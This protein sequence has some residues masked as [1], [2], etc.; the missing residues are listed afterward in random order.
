[1]KTKSIL[2]V[3][4]CIIMVVGFSQQDVNPKSKV[5]VN[6]KNDNPQGSGSSSSTGLLTKTNFGE[7]CSMYLNESFQKGVLVLNDNTEIGDRLY[8]FNIYNQQMEFIV[9]E[10]TTAIGNPE[11][12]RLLKF[13][14]KYFIYTQYNYG[15]KVNAGY[16]EVLVDGDYRLLLHRDIKYTFKEDVT[17][18]T[19]KP[20]ERYY[21]GKRYFISYKNEPANHIL[22][23]KKDVVNSVQIP[24]KDLKEYMKERKNH[25]KSESDLVEVFR[26]CNTP[27]D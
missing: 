10:D 15:Q 8:R 11:E 25:M 24:G 22:L 2:T 17:D 5:K 14:G 12:L 18:P 4:M 19:A 1:M 27:V 3:A 23:D 26:Y 7:E 20:V 16:M 21:L 6:Y 13:D 9:N